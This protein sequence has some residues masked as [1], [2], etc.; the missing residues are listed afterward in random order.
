MKTLFKLV[1]ALLVLNAAARGAWSMWT[2]SQFKEA[3][4]Q[5]VLFGQK[6]T[7]EELESGIL[8]K[9]SEFHLNVRPDDI[10]ITKDSART[11]A[12]ASYTQPVEFFPN[13][14]YPVKFSFQVD[15]VSFTGAA[16]IGRRQP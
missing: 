6:S 3:T 12:E 8:A 13:Y 11:I 4:Q 14:A 16:P 5:L 15:A 10:V 7:P 9:A 1:I 2:Y